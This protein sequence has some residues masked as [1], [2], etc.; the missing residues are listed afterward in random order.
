MKKKNTPT[1]DKNW[2]SQLMGA[3]YD[4]M[5]ELNSEHSQEQRKILINMMD[6]RLRFIGD[7]NFYVT[8]DQDTIMHHCAQLGSID[9]MKILLSQ[10][11]EVNIKNKLSHTPLYSALMRPDFSSEEREEKM[12]MI[13]LLLE[14][15]ADPNVI[16]KGVDHDKFQST[17]DLSTSLK[18]DHDTILHA[19]AAQS[20]TESMKLLLAYGGKR[21]INTPNIFGHTPL[22]AALTRSSETEEERNEKLAM[23]RILLE[24]GAKPHSL[25]KSIDP[26]LFQPGDVDEPFQDPLTYITKDNGDTVMHMAATFLDP[27]IIDLFIEFRGNINIL[28]EAGQGPLSFAMTTMAANEKEEAKKEKMFRHLLDRNANP[29]KQDISRN[30]VYHWLNAEYASIVREKKID[31]YQNWTKEQKDVIDLEILLADYGGFK[32]EPLLKNGPPSDK[33]IQDYKNLNAIYNEKKQYLGQRENQDIMYWVNS[34]FT[35]M[36]ITILGPQLIQKYGNYVSEAGLDLRN[37]FVN[38]GSRLSMRTSDLSDSESM[39]TPL[40]KLM[41]NKCYGNKD[42]TGNLSKMLK[43]AYKYKLQ[44]SKINKAIDKRE[45]GLLE[46][47]EYKRSGKR[48]NTIEKEAIIKQPIKINGYYVYESDNTAETSANGEANISCLSQYA[49]SKQ[50]IFVIRKQKGKLVPDPNKNERKIPKKDGKYRSSYI[51]DTELRMVP[52]EKNHQKTEIQIAPFKKVIGYNNLPPPDPIQEEIQD[53]ALFIEYL[54]RVEG[55]FGDLR[56]A[57]EAIEKDAKKRD[58]D[59]D[60]A[61]LLI[62]YNPTGPN[63]KKDLEEAVNAWNDLL[64]DTIRDIRLLDFSKDLELMVTK[65]EFMA[66]EKYKEK[67]KLKLKNQ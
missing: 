26:A 5:F 11:G 55:E 1:K 16:I 43:G 8:A 6:W 18:K 36:A 9:V 19:C 2:A 29:F 15:G 52:S 34:A 32:I 25:I 14:Y 45:T 61:T 44:E 4:E 41:A 58:I 22:Y 28:N 24:N 53:I 38:L 30:S 65:G 21:N 27:D 40:G 48:T 31:G 17:K 67:Q 56:E 12:A 66:P 46:V 59:Y 62:G 51:I 37:H 42:G 39:T 10:E 47:E 20:D 60:K 49:L 7:A 63:A 50:H 3:F 57:Y 54:M 35:Q 23:L 64:G 13:R 33:D